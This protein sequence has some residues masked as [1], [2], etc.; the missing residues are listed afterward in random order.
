MRSTRESLDSSQGI[1][2]PTW[3]ERVWQ[4]HHT[5][6][7]RGSRQAERGSVTIDGRSV[8]ARA[9]SHQIGL[10]FQDAVLL[11][12]RTVSENVSLP[13]EVL[14]IPRRERDEQ[15]QVGARLWLA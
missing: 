8:D 11:P 10:V 14:K 3:A 5:V 9:P 1:R 13:L 12:W 2:L 7:D 15:D 4:V 6:A